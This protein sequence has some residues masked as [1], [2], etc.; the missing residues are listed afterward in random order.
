MPGS[1][2]G[3]LEITKNV[4]IKQECDLVFAH[5]LCKAMFNIITVKE[6]ICFSYLSPCCD[7]Y[8]MV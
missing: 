2:L 8:L 3:T 7:K 4:V 1:V 5:V 6:Y